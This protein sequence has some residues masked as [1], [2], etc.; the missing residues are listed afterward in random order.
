MARLIFAL[1]LAM[2]AFSQATILPSIHVIRV[3]PNVVLVLLLAWCAMRGTAEG[4]IWVFGAG[5]L[6][7]VL[8]LDPLGTNGLALL[9]VAL[10]AGPSRRRFFHSGLVFPIVL[11]VVATFVHA[12]VLLLIR[13]EG[14]GGL[15]IG[16][17]FRL[18]TLQAMLN[19]LLVPPIYLIAGLM[20]R[21]VVQ[22]NV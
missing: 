19:A 12:L 18:V 17:V 3:L 8:A 16:S 4:L 21:W 2:A 15:P 22:A 6:I 14:G 7:D 13:S 10:L 5:L 9:I 1:L 11:V 20:D